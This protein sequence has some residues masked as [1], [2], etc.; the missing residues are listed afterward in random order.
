MESSVGLGGITLVLAAVV[1]LLIFVPGYAK[2]SQLRETTTL[3]RKEHRALKRAAGLSNDERMH[4]LINTQR[5][6][7]VLFGLA[8][9]GVIACA[10]AAV[11]DGAWWFGFYASSITAILALL[12][13]RAA[14]KSAAALATARHRSK[15]ASRDVASRTTARAANRDWT[16]NPLPEPLNRPLS[17]E[18]ATPLAD[19]IAIAKP[20]TKLTGSEIDAILARRRAI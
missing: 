4:R 20:K 6:F 8:L 14:G 13:Q 3:V 17:G 5:G 19:V 12:I 16:P 1:W 2:R 11:S 15:L 10:V 18:I 9:L 7:S